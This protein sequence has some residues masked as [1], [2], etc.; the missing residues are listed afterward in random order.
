M[1]Y[2]M[3]IV[4]NFVYFG[5]NLSTPP[6]IKKADLSMPAD[7]NGAN[8]AKILPVNFVH[9]L[10][11]TKDAIYWSDLQSIN[12]AG[13]NG[14]NPTVLY[15]P[16]NTQIRGVVLLEEATTS[17]QPSISN[18]GRVGNNFIF[19]VQA[20]PGK[21]VLV[22]K[23]SGYPATS[24]NPIINFFAG[25]DPASITNPISDSLKSEIFRAKSQ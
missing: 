4:G 22:E 18:A 8:V 25:N 23:T 12:R 14:E 21:A 2:D 7:V 24:W 20:A 9:G 3:Q 10:C 11:V 5:D 19:S 15:S 13:L 6:S 17:A 16:A 1:V